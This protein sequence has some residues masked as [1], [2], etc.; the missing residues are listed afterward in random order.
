MTTKAQDDI[1][2]VLRDLMLWGVARGQQVSGA[3]L[4]VGVDLLALGEN[5]NDL[6]VRGRLV[7]DV[8]ILRL[9]ARQENRMAA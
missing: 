1:G 2:A 6:E 9:A 3:V 4:R 5:E 7:I 8:E